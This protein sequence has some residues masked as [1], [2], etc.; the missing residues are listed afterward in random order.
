MH[1][2]PSIVAYP[3]MYYGDFVIVS[4][5]TLV[6]V[7]MGFEKTAY[8]VTEREYEVEFCICVT[9]APVPA[10]FSVVVDIQDA[11]TGRSIYQVLDEITMHA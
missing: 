1:C 7:Q 5:S 3:C 4:S 9:E 6:A 8:T 11:S 2:K 10:N